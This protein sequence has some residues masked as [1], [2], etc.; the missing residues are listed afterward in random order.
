M[1]SLLSHPKV[2]VFVGDGFKFL[3]ENSSAYDVIITDSSD[4][5][6]PAESL[7]QKP[8]FQ[9]LY[10]ALTP[11][12]HISTQAEC[13]WLH[14]PLIKEL[15][16]T[17]SDMFPVAEYAYTT[18]PTYPS[19]QIGF[20]VCS[21][22]KGRNLKVPVRKVSGTI[23][24][25]ESAHKAAFILPEFGRSIVEEGKDITPKFGRAALQQQVAGMPKRKILLL[26]SGYVARPAAEYILRNPLNELTI[27]CRTLE[28]AKALAQG[29]P[30]ST[31]ISL[32]VASTAE[33]ESVVAAHDLVISLIPY[34][35]HSAVIKAAIKGKT[36]VVTTSYVSPSMR[37]LDEE[38]KKA[39]IVVMNEIGLDPG[40]DHLYAIKI[41]DE[42]HAKGGKV[43]TL[44]FA[45]GS[46]EL[47]DNPHS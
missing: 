27:A 23:Y 31:W 15:L 19:G 20:L 16:S 26:G 40:I 42:V 24:Y 25:N 5:V 3:A 1:S 47:T 34:T 39:G 22:E 43:C 9:L 17:T 12:G 18:I 29:L 45:S 10:D 13:L 21:K 38:A 11:G 44:L 4:P 46:I 35:Y 2:T 32:D 7:F 36:H 33:L 6:G 30:N 14:L 28:N 41:I 37:E 8:Y